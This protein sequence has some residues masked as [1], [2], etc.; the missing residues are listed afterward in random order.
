MGYGVLKSA[1]EKEI[2]K[3][4]YGGERKRRE[5]L[6]EKEA[7]ERRRSRALEHGLRTSGPS[8][9]A[10]R[11][12]LWPLVP[13]AA[14]PGVILEE[15]LPGFAGSHTAASS[16]RAARRS[17]E[18]P[19]GEGR[20]REREEE[21]SG[22]WR[23]RRTRGGRRRRGRRRRRRRGAAAEPLARLR[24]A[25]LQILRELQPRGSRAPAALP[26]NFSCSYIPSHL[27]YSSKKSETEQRHREGVR[28]GVKPQQSN[29]SLRAASPARSHNPASGVKEPTSEK[30]P[31][32][33]GAAGGSGRSGA[34]SP[35]SPV[36][37]PE[38][39]SLR[40]LCS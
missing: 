39:R 20:G 16:P 32:S 33:R 18:K 40:Q 9:A 21:G 34:P 13:G 3:K 4:E 27:I 25:T 35:P 14:N 29:K 2:D 24:R 6:G 19:A 22:G 28:G 31:R 12:R 15:F 36:E 26:P 11:S 38:P 8:A 30:A 37:P 17:P 7:R 5:R 10:A 1:S 23:R